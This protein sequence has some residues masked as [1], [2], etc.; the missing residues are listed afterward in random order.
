MFFDVREFTRSY[1]GESNMS[2]RYKGIQ[3]LIFK[4]QL[5]AYYTNFTDH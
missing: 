2:G 1:K 3:A 4:E 5:M